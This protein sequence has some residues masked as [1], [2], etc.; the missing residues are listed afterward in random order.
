MI[1]SRQECVLSKV[2]LNRNVAQI[3]KDMTIFFLLIWIRIFELKTLCPQA[4][5]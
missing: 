4:S 5:F 1:L 3:F 2:E